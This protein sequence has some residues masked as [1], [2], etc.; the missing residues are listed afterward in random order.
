MLSDLR[1]EDCEREAAP[2]GA[3]PVAADVGREDDI[4][5]LVTATIDRFGRIDLFVSNAGI[6]IDGGIDTPTDSVAEDHRRQ[7]DV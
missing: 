4:A 3:F 6:A 1:Q 2:I 7:P 5:N